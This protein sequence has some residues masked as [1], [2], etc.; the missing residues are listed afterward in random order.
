MKKNLLFIIML[1]I[2]LL[3]L[4]AQKNK[5]V[6]FLNNG[7]KI[8]GNIVEIADNQYKIK[9]RE[10]SIFIVPE[11]DVD[12][13]TD[14]SADYVGRK[15]NGFGF[16][17]EGGGL[18]GV[19]TEE[20]T[21]PFSFNILGN[22]TLR[23]RNKFGVGSGVEYMGQAYMPVFAEYKFLFFDRKTTPFFFIRGGKLIHKKGDSESNDVYNN[24]T[25]KDYSGGLTTTIGTGISWSGDS[26]EMYLSF[27]FRNAH[28]SYTQKNYN[29][30]MATYKTTLNRLE[31][32]FGFSF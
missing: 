26:N 12:R 23:T 24:N 7:S 25:N 5:Q 13:Y 19:K 16:V 29:Y 28:T 32:K 31:V 21:T 8:F 3:P 17:I 1:I 2:S 20:Y 27:A 9:T 6:L 4:T 14:E 10:G 30:Q 22:L 15:S 18:F 11:A